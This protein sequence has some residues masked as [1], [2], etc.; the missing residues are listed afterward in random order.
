VSIF[1][2]LFPDIRMARLSMNSNSM[3]R[4]PQQMPFIKS[5]GGDVD[6]DRT[7]VDPKIAG[8]VPFLGF[9]DPKN[10]RS[11]G[12]PTTAIAAKSTGSIIYKAPALVWRLIGS[13][14]GICAATALE[15]ICKQSG[16]T[17]AMA[18]ECY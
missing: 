15:E 4:Q 9:F 3:Q 1:L 2:Y 12:R 16:K 7:V 8:E 17:C 18:S 13:C 11:D 10:G 14:Q 5:A 6:S